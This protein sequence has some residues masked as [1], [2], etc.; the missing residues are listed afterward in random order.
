MP[1]T[2]TGDATKRIEALVYNLSDNRMRDL[3]VQLR[4]SLVRKLAGVQWSGGTSVYIMRGLTAHTEPVR[5]P[6][7]GWMCGVGSLDILHREDA[8]PR[9]IA[10]FLE[11]Y[12]QQMEEKRVER[13][14]VRERKAAEARTA[15]I[16]I[17]SINALNDSYLSLNAQLNKGLK[18]FEAIDRAKEK[19]RE[20]KAARVS[21]TEASMRMKDRWQEQI[22]E[23]DR[24]WSDLVARQARIRAQQD[25]ISAT[26]RKQWGGD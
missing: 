7:G 6:T 10:D 5:T 22:N 4:D 26:I 9:T 2:I 21:L 13:R 15:R 25:Q 20:K 17:E 24:E 16:R 11:W 14:E 1:V 8:P 12:R 23:L 18:R 3:T 19:L